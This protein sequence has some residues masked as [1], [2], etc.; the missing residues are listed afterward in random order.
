MKPT[1]TFVVEE[2]NEA[3]GFARLRAERGAGLFHCGLFPELPGG[4][5]SPLRLQVG[6]RVSGLRRGQT[7]SHLQWL[8]RAAPPEALVREMEDLVRQLEA[9][10][11]GV[12]VAPESLA[13][14]RWREGRAARSWRR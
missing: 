1:D 9:R 13:D 4:E 6:D 2:T 3:H 7:V 11:L 5:R 8:S 14:H 10:G 12:S